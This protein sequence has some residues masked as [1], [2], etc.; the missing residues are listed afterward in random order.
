MILKSFYLPTT[1][2]HLILASDSKEV[3]A[4]Q[5]SVKHGTYLSHNFARKLDATTDL[6]RYLPDSYDRRLS[7]HLEYRLNRP[8]L[9]L[10]VVQS[11]NSF[12]MF[13]VSKNIFNW[14]LF[15]TIIIDKSKLEDASKYGHFL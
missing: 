14:A 12:T 1:R 6:I 9:G 10:D 11:H 5:F 13:Q 2:S 4:H 7:N 3:F 8:M 15:L